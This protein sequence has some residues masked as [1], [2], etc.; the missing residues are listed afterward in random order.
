MTSDAELVNRVRRGDREAFGTL[1]ARYERSVLAVAVAELRDLQTAEDVTSTTLLLAFQ[2]LATLKD[3]ASFGPWLMQ[4][5]RRQIVDAVRGRRETVAVSL[6]TAPLIESPDADWIE[7]EQLLGLVARLPEHE[8]W[9][10]GMRYFD[11][12][13]MSEIAVSTG[14]PIGTVTKQLSR[15]IARL[16][17]W[18]D[19]ETMP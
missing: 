5:A 9:L 2:K 11:G 19:E 6:D 7:H 17:E 3:A 12:L 8:R 18:L 4:I 16:R 13:S 15:A 1:I 14:R 10:V